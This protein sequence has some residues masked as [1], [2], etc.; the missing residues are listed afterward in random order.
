[1]FLGITIA[2]IIEVYRKD[3]K[4]STSGLGLIGAVCINLCGGIVLLLWL[5]FGDLGLPA[6]G[7]IFLGSLA[8]MLLLI[9]TVELLYAVRSRKL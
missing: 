3:S 9:S 5:V 6:K 8:L 7:Y 1:M 4:N 2:L